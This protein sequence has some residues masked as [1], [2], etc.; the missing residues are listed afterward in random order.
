MKHL[1]NAIAG[2][3]VIGVIAFAFEV[4]QLATTVSLLLIAFYVIHKRWGLFNALVLSGIP[5]LVN[6]IDSFPGQQ[7]TFRHLMAS[8]YALCLIILI[9]RQA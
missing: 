1:N 6:V 4:A 9:S 2:A 3:L 7:T 5:I 8:L